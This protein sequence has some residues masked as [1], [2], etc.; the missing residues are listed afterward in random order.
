MG[1]V[2]QTWA[3]RALRVGSGDGYFRR[4]GRDLLGEHGAPSA[5]SHPAGWCVRTR[6]PVGNQEQSPTLC[7]PKGAAAHGRQA[8]LVLRVVLGECEF[9]WFSQNEE[10]PQCPHRNY[11]RKLMQ[12]FE[13]KEGKKEQKKKK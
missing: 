7:P 9:S 13:R 3:R 10:A 1:A 4:V 11:F 12:T 2:G 5:L 8:T 6:V